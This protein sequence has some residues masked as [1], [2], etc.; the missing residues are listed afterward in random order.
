MRESI[1]ADTGGPAPASGRVEEL[2]RRL[3]AAQAE[4]EHIARQLSD[5]Q[6]RVVE[7]ESDRNAALNRIE[8]ALDSLHTLNAARE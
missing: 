1:M 8:W 3:A 4:R 7:L 2:E 6:A 5:C